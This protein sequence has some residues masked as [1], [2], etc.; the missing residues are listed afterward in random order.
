[1]EIKEKLS[2]VFLSN[3]INC[4]CEYLLYAKNNRKYGV[5]NIVRLN[6]TYI[7]IKM[8]IFEMETERK[9]KFHFAYK[10]V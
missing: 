4:N 1:M 10:K 8:L 5:L 7:F 6:T 3:V 9:S 2:L